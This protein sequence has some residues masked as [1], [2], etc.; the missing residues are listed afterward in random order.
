RRAPPTDVLARA[1]RLLADWVGREGVSPPQRGELERAIAE[2]HGATGAIVRWSVR[3]H[4]PRT[5]LAN[6]PDWRAKVSPSKADSG[7]FAEADIVLAE[8][9][10]VEF[11]LTGPA[12]PE[13]WLNGRSIY[14]RARATTDRN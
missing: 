1:A 3:E 5:V 2:V 4:V 13:V 7:G 10:A 8:A 9:T 6:P 11:A 14:R 12:V